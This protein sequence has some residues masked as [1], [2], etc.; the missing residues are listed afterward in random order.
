I[1]CAFAA[2]SLD[3]GLTAAAQ[4]SQVPPIARLEASLNTGFVVALPVAFL[5]GLCFSAALVTSRMVMTETAP[6]GQQARV[7]ATQMTLTDAVI[8]LPLVI[9]GVG[10]EFAGARAT[11]AVV[12]A[13]GL[14]LFVLMELMVAGNAAANARPGLERSAAGPVRA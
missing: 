3:Y 9:A 6:A 2:A 7:F 4:Y 1:I 13:L 5:L 11:L 10:V 12:G 14:G 8:L